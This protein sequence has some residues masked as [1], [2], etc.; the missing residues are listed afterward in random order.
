M[1]SQQHQMY[2]LTHSNLSIILY[3]YSQLTYGNIIWVQ[4]INTIR[5]RRQLG[6]VTLN[7]NLAVNEWVGL[8]YDR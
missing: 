4:N 6:F 3:F 8:V 7:G 2:Q 1:Q 5:E